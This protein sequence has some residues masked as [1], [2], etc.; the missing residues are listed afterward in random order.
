MTLMNYRLISG[1]NG[2]LL[3]SHPLQERLH[4][5]ARPPAGHAEGRREQ[6]GS[7]RERRVLGQ[8]QS[9]KVAK[10]VEAFGGGGRS[11]FPPTHFQ[12][13]FEDRLAEQQKW[14]ASFWT[15]PLRRKEGAPLLGGSVLTWS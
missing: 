3:I 5:L 15:V 13:N 6:Q 2:G 1:A 7:W 9:Q 10:R 12:Q 8:E 4:L 11:F 14:S